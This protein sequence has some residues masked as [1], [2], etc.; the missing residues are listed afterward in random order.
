LQNAVQKAS[1]AIIAEKGLFSG[2][3]LLNFF[4]DLI[5]EAGLKRNATFEDLHLKV[6]ESQRP[7][8]DLFITALN[9]KDGLTTTF[10]FDS[11]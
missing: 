4:R 7:M 10:S 9:L 3:P 8:K 1:Y 5:E 11:P 6:Q 2:E